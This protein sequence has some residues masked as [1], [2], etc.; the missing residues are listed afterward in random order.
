MDNKIDYIGGLSLGAQ[1]A[2]MKVHSR[3]AASIGG[4]DQSPLIASAVA[5]NV[6][7]IDDRDIYGA[8]ELDD[9]ELLAAKRHLYEFQ[10]RF[11]PKKRNVSKIAAEAF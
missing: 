10:D 4:D 7:D 8:V 2:L 3:T 1:D 9:V 6:E 5:H 11:L